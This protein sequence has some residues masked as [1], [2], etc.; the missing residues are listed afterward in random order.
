MRRPDT[1]YI[2]S[3][4]PGPEGALVVAMWGGDSSR[5]VKQWVEHGLNKR[6]GHSS[7]VRRGSLPPLI[8]A[9]ALMA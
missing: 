5:I 3:A 1:L 6:P 2:S 4:L 7:S 9:T 8:K